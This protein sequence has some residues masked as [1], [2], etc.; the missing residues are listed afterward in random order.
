VTQ[1][2]QFGSAKSKLVKLLLDG[3]ED[4]KLNRDDWLRLLTWIDTNGSYRGTFI[5]V[6]DWG[7]WG[8]RPRPAD[9]QAVK[10]IQRRRCDSCH[11]KLLGGLKNLA[12]KAKVSAT[13]EFN[14]NFAARFAVDG[15]SVS[16]WAVKGPKA[17]DQ[18]EFTLQWDKP[19]E[20]AQIVYAGRTTAILECWKD[21][22]VY[23]DE[24][25]APA[26]KGTL[27][28]V[29]GP[30]LIAV[31]K[32]RARKVRLK[33]LNSHTPKFNPGASEIA[34][35]SSSPSDQQLARFPRSVRK[36]GLARPGWIHPRDPRNSL[37]LLAPL[38]TKAGG[39]GKCKPGVFA[40]TS[41]PDY[42]ALLGETR[43]IWN[44]MRKDP[45]PGMKELIA[46]EANRPA[47]Q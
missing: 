23:L 9:M 25:S 42:Q 47:K 13:S 4:A 44:R 24:D 6:H 12:P 30:Q 37:Y 11:D 17:G 33:F 1:P 26:A 18:A 10:A 8:Y 28:N 34:V 29:R 32:R 20:V 43:K 19:V 16:N 15:K 40:D 41:D 38:A 14:G 36:G 45:T 39:W 22:E 27:R 31:K 21:Y 46:A 2:Y 7:R 3:H 5:S 35:Y